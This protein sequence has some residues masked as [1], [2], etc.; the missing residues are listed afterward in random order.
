MFVLGV[1]GGIGSGKS[2]VTERFE[3]LGIEV[4]DADVAARTV[5]AAGQPALDQISERFGSNI[6][7][8]N[9]ELDR[10]ALRKIVFHNPDE[11]K[12]LEGLTHPLIREEIIKGLQS[13]Q[14]PYVI[15]VSP[16][17]IESGQFHFTQ[18]I[19][20]VDVPESTQIE[21]TCARDN[22][23]AAQVQ[24]II[25]A[26]INRTERLAKA[27]DIIENNLGLDHLDSEVAR[28]HSQYLSL[29]ADHQ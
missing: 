19:L 2:A 29:A 22:N 11:R 21:R 26:Q 9:G 13:A 27:D 1:T 5:V 8:E 14:S 23:D 10:A 25:D 6:L 28:L 15:L 17:L 18:R 7:L 24:A 20:V 12:W 4:V 3:A 16:L